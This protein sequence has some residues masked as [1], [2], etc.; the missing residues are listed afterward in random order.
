[1]ASAYLCGP[2]PLYHLLEESS[3]ES[4]IITL[5]SK[6][7]PLLSPQPGR[8]FPIASTSLNHLSTGITLGVLVRQRTSLTPA[9]RE[10]LTSAGT[11]ILSSNRCVTLDCHHGLL[12]CFLADLYPQD[13]WDLPLP[14][15]ISPLEES[16]P[17]IVLSA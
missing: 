5:A 14:E 15:R 9:L 11:N 8:L 7:W 10:A 1:M 16:D 2:L 3:L 12:L 6:T 13:C 4:T 17:Q